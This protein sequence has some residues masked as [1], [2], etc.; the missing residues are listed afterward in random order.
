MKQ[1]L[2]TYA[3][4][5]ILLLG[6][7]ALA[8]TNPVPIV[9]QPLVPMTVKPGS[10]GF[11]L[12]VN[13]FG[14]AGDALVAWNGNTRI[15]TVVSNTQ[16]QVQ[17]KASD[18][19]NPGTANVSVVNP[20]P[21]G[22]TSN[23]VLF[24][25]QTTTSFV[26]VFPA[27]GFSGSGV[28]AVGDLN[29][30]GLL[31]LAVGRDLFIDFYAGKGDGSFAT[32]FSSHSVVPVASMLAVDFDADGDPDLAVLDGLGST[33]VF[34]NGIPKGNLVQQQL[35]RSW[36]GGLAAGDINGDGKLDLVITGYNSAVRLGNGDGTFGQP[37]FF[38][39]GDFRT[40]TPAVGDFDGD[41]KLDLAVPQSNGINIYL[42]IGDGTF[43]SGDVI[44][45]NVSA[46]A[47]ADFDGD[48]ILD[49]ATNGVSVYLGNGDG[50]FRGGARNEPLKV[51]D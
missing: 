2:V 13:G 46:V 45:D 34:L 10:K 36:N 25:I 4:A 43:R 28:N 50:T 8:Q 9:Y 22:G 40:G 24:P 11:T 44:Q 12:T 33:A 31:D 37:L 49:I 16:L 3:F 27:A 5:F 47:V 15:T 19:A 51:P 38:S 23:V 21:G 39:K 32:P 14:F 18:V 29:N 30:D 20:G 1:L 26:A 7:V 6:S 17:V 42:G 48:G 35:F 41:G